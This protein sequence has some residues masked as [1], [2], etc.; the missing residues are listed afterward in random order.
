M[1]W[2]LADGS[3]VNFEMYKAITCAYI[4]PNAANFWHPILQGRWVI[5]LTILQK[6]LDIL[7]EH[8]FNILK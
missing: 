8:Q 6:Q 1:M 5:A 7:K 2:L 3:K 4:E